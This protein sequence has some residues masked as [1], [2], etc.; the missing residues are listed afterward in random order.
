M[1]HGNSPVLGTAG[2]VDQPGGCEDVGMTGS[3]REQA[4][5]R[6]AH[7][8]AL[9]ALGGVLFGYPL[10]AVFDVPARVLGVPVLWAYLFVAWAALVTAVAVAMRRLS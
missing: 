7:L 10:L 2:L 3:D 8:V 4:E 5:P 6:R 1:G 9:A